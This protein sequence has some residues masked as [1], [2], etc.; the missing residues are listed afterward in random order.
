M[1]HDFIEMVCE[2]YG[3][4]GMSPPIIKVIPYGDME[5]VLKEAENILK[6]FEVKDEQRVKDNIAEL[7]LTPEER[8][9]PEFLFFH[10]VWYYYRPRVKKMREA[11]EKRDHYAFLEA[12]QDF[13]DSIYLK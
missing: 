6:E 1:S 2:G 8:E 11:F 4:K 5:K 13:V 9:N 10:P 3:A 12:T 7:A